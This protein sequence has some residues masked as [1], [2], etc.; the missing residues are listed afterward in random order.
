MLYW[1]IY[2]LYIIVNKGW[3]WKMLYTQL[4]V[5][6]KQFFFFIGNMHQKRDLTHTEE[7]WEIFKTN[8]IQKLLNY[9]MTTGQQNAHWV[10]GL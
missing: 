6:I 10:I 7:S 8:A 5:I 3:K 9:I 1:I 2:K 4:C